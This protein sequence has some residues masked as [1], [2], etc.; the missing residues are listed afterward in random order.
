MLMQRRHIDI[1]AL[2]LPCANN[3]V[4]AQPRHPRFQCRPILQMQR[5]A[6]GR[7]LLDKRLDFAAI[8]R[9][10][11][12]QRSARRKIPAFAQEPP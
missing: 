6:Q 8:S 3:P 1:R 11:D 7:K 12:V 10:P 4:A 2:R 9:A 5:R